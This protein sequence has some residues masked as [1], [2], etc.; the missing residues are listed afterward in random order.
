MTIHLPSVFYGALGVAIVF[1]FFPVLAQK[2]AGW[3]RKAWE[4]IKAFGLKHGIGSPRD[5]A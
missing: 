4:K 5:Q 3:L 2:P 1:T